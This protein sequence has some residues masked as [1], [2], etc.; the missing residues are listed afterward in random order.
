MKR[1]RRRR[2]KDAARTKFFSGRVVYHQDFRGS[3]EESKT[4]RSASQDPRHGRGP[5]PPSSLPSFSAVNPCRR[6][7]LLFICGGALFDSWS[8]DDDK[9]EQK[10]KFVIFFSSFPI[11]LVPSPF[12]LLQRE[13]EREKRG[14]GTTLLTSEISAGQQ[15]FGPFVRTCLWLAADD[16]HAGRKKTRTTESK[17]AGK[18]KK[19]KL[20]IHHSKGGVKA[21][22]ILLAFAL[23]LLPPP[24]PSQCGDG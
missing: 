7:L 22:I 15:Q 19:K 11:L 5:L 2:R 9:E 6:L 10:K 18:K 14:P 3:A 12:N 16:C 4:Y 8:S 17:E 24:S 1:E 13:R 23:L 20:L 21:F